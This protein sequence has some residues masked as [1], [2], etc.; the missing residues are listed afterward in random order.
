MV[1]P[2]YETWQ[3]SV[4]DSVA[5]LGAELVGAV[6]GVSAGVG[7]AVVGT[8]GNAVVGQMTL[9]APV[10]GGPANRPTWI[11]PAQHS[12]RTPPIDAKTIATVRREKRLGAAC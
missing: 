3:I 4:L 1:A 11:A 5:A 2:L 10:L 12:T 9:A 7:L 8:A 6:D